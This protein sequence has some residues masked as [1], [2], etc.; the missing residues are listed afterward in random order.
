MKNSPQMKFVPWL[1]A[2][3]A[4]VTALVTTS[5]AFD[6]PS[7]RPKG[8]KTTVPVIVDDA[9][10]ARETKLSSS[11]SPVIKKVAPS[12]VNVYSTKRVKNAYGPDMFPFSDDPLFRRFFG[13]QSN[14]RNLLND[15]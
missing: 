7:F 13:N 3:A 5:L 11:F 9:P 6:W 14:R 1:V 8:V 12:V 2:A 15:R 10:L 4:G